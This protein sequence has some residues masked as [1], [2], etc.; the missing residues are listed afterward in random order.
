MLE[1]FGGNTSA[2]CR[3][4]GRKIYVNKAEV[5]ER[6]GQRLVTLLCNKPYCPLYARPQ[7]YG[8]MMDLDIRA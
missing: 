4:C 7:R 6:A 2:K 8:E 1:N 3:G 5:T